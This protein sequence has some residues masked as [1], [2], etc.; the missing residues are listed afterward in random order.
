MQSGRRGHAISRPP[1]LAQR[2][3]K[4]T[5]EVAMMID[6][7]PLAPCRRYSRRRSDRG[8]TLIEIMIVLALMALI[9]TA[10]TLTIVHRWKEGQ[11]RTAQIQIREVAGNVHSYLIARGECPSM[12]ELIAGHYVRSE[13][14]D[15]W[16]TPVAVR[17]PG[18]RDP[19]GVD[20]VSYGPDRREG[21][22]DDIRSWKL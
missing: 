9:A 20:V 18:E 14:R 15:P 8:M 12:D 7:R 22:D 11:V 19:D 6:E 1:L 10:L 16:G 13:P 5:A 4:A 21:T 3:L 2:L 17:C